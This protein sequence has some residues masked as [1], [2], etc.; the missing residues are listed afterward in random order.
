ML[1]KDG[2]FLKARQYGLFNDS[3]KN[4]LPFGPKILSKFEPFDRC[5]KLQKNSLFLAI[6]YLKI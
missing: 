1:K 2:D 5:K 6:W 4:V 3:I